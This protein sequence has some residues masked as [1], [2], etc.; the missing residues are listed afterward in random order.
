M[1]T[2]P[3]P[4]RGAALRRSGAKAGSGYDK[5]DEGI[6]TV[7]DLRVDTLVAV[8]PT[9][10]EEELAQEEEERK[11]AIIERARSGQPYPMPPRNLPSTEFPQPTTIQQ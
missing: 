7:I 11:A 1:V 5:V 2:E 9:K 4:R 3:G 8:R 6:V 10:S